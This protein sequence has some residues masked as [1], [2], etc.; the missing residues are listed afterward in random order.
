[1]NKFKKYIICE[2]EIGLEE[3][4][5]WAIVEAKN[6]DEAF[7]LFIKK[8]GIYNK[9]FLCNLDMLLIDSFMIN[10]D[11]ITEEYRKELYDYF[12]GNK[13]WYNCILDICSGK[14]KR[15]YDQVMEKLD[16]RISED[17]LIFIYKK[18]NTER[19]LVLD[20]NYHIIND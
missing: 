6:K 17:M 4:D 12:N 1:M 7:D 5:S 11:I 3:Y 18:E 2:K 20:K 19:M 8:K 13:E 14:E 15:I 16:S 10:R 9:A